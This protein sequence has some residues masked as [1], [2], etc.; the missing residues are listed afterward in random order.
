MRRSLDNV[1]ARPRLDRRRRDI[2]P[3]FAGVASNV[4]Q[5]VIRAG[6][7]VFLSFGEGAIVKTVQ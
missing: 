3:R 7:D 5:A 1:D 6:P 2:G 4:N